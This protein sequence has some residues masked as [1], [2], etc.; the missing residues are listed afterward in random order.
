MKIPSGRRSKKNRI[1]YL[2]PI[3]VFI[4]AI[5]ILA[6]PLYSVH[7]DS[8]KHATN[9]TAAAEKNR[10]TQVFSRPADWLLHPSS[11]LAAPQQQ[12]PSITTYAQDCTTPRS[13]F[14]LGETVCAKAT[15]VPVTIFSWHVSWVDPV[16]FVRQ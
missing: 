3:G 2:I 9:E 14:L 5:S 12:S 1:N 15:G 8:L 6:V 7:S 13:D 4:F 16:G 11:A 10:G